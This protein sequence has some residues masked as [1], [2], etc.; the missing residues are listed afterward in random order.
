MPEFV[1]YPVEKLTRSKKN[2]ELRTRAA[3]LTKHAKQFRQNNREAIWKRS[4]KQYRGRHWDDIDTT[5]DRITINMSFSTVN[6]IVP[7]VTG[8]EPDFVV[9]P[10]SGE[11]TT[12]TARLVT[13]WL[14]RLWRSSRVEGNAHLERSAWDYLVY[15]DGYMK[16]SYVIVDEEIDEEMKEVAEIWVDRINPWD[17]WLDPASDGLHNSRYVIQRLFI[18]LSIIK[19]DPRYRN[20]SDLGGQGASAGEDTGREE[21][22]LDLDTNDQGDDLIE[23]YEFYDNLRKQLVVWAEGSDMP[24]RVVDDIE[25]PIVQLGNY[26]IPNNPYHMGEM[27]QLWEMQQELNRTRSDMITHRQRN[28]AKYVAQE[29]NV[30]ENAKAALQS[31]EVGEIVWIKGNVDPST[32]IRPL[33]VAQLSPDSYQLSDIITRDIYEISGVNEYLR[34][35][36]P[37]ITRTATEATIIEGASNVKSQHKLRQVESF[38]KRVGQ[39]IVK[40]A[41]A[42]Y[43]ET[44]AEEMTMILTGREAQ[45]VFAAEKQGQASQ[46]MDISAQPPAE[47]VVDAEFNLGSE[48]WKGTF[49]VFVRKYSTEL[50]NPV[51]K[52]QKYK[53]MFTILLQA[54]PQLAEMGATVPNITK[55][56]E[57]W[58][59]AAGIDDI[60]SILQPSENQAAKQQEQQAMQQQMQEAELAAQQG[61][62]E[63]GGPLGPGGGLAP[64]PGAPNPEKAKP[65][66]QVTP[67]NSGILGADKGQT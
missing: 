7:Y 5:G 48:I 51:A 9:E 17:L 19:N 21:G 35:A 40:M 31:K 41:A 43:P 49:E 44:D 27:E 57:L 52:E 65:P 33:E 46:G 3:D 2:L 28:V 53:E 1:G 14:N 4:E 26:I 23:V 58:L 62:E 38:V 24:L 29:G 25:C 47:A 67:Q 8:A 22:V 10:Y 13:A 30:D 42:V 39:M 18:P 32:V 54:A 60:D 59:E 15:G 55:V 66:P 45:A 12:A 20:K 61:G 37:T 11:A 56:M 16:Q 6:T 64:Q 63:Q 36:T 50:R 34:G